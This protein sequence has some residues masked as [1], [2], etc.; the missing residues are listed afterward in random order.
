MASGGQFAVDPEALHRAA[1]VFDGAA[2][3]LAGAVGR[4]AASA[5]PAAEAFGL[6]PQAAA[7]HARYVAL[8]AAARDGLGDVH[9]ALGLSLAGGLRTSAANYVRAD[10]DSTA[11]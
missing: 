8:A 2:E 3:R 11:R 9:G 4:F 7:A 10:Q 1:G 6:L 5:Q